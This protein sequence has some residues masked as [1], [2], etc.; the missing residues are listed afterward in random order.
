MS[1]D[2]KREPI[3]PIFVSALYFYPIKSCSGISLEV[4]EI[5]QRGIRGDRAFMVVDL[6]GRFITQRE[7][8]RM[9]L[10]RPIL[11]EDGAVTVTAPDM[12]EISLVA[13][14]TGKRYD[15]VIWRDTCVGVDQGDAIAAWFST[16]LG[17]ACRVV[18]M[19]EDYMRQVDPHYAIGE[20][21]QVAF[22]DGYPFLLVAE[23]SLVDLN[24]R[25]E[26]PVPIDRF[27][28]NIVIKGTVPYVEDMWRKISIGHM[29]FHIVKA[30]GR[31][32]IITT[33]Q[34]MAIVGK[35]PL[36][37]LATYRRAQKGV[38]F[39]Q[40]MIHMHEGK[41]RVGDAVEVIKQAATANC[42]LRV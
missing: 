15:V 33:D 19:P 27:R 37:T 42:D 7:Q 29:V 21:D 39:G 34:S 1:A 14:N 25:M 8:P 31:C 11:R 5:D 40:N 4:A 26:E 6:A 36:K 2:R 3:L 35:E 17:M 23:A 41:I 13:D 38:M 20:Q 16:F 30:C 18:H 22:A 24:A 28:P 32:P 9:A 10:I 12:P